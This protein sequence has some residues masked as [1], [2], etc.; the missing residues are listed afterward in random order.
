METVQSDK[1]RSGEVFLTK[2]DVAKLFQITT[3]SVDDWMRRR[4]LPHYKIGRAV[5]FRLKDLERHLE[6]AHRI[7]ARGTSSFANN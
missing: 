2:D 3:R 5:R 6:S 4:L 7:A 1:P